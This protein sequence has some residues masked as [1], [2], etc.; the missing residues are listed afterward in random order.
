MSEEIDV[1]K[2]IFEYSE[3]LDDFGFSGITEVDFEQINQ[4]PV[5]AANSVQTTMN[6]MCTAARDMAQ[7]PPHS[8]PTAHD[9]QLIESDDVMTLTGVV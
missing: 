6:R 8:C 2:I 1:D 4:T 9:V 7:A 5:P 3:D